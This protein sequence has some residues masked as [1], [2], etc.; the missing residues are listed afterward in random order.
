MGRFSPLTD[1]IVRLIVRQIFETTEW[2][3]HLITRCWKFIWLQDC[4]RLKLLLDS[5][6]CVLNI[7]RH[8]S[9]F[10]CCLLCDL[11]LCKLWTWNFLFDCLAVPFWVESFYRWRLF[12]LRL[13]FVLLFLIQIYTIWRPLIDYTRLFLVKTFHH[14][15]L[16]TLGFG[17]DLLF[18]FICRLWATLI[19][20][21][22]DRLHEAFRKCIALWVLIVMQNQFWL[23]SVCFLF[24]HSRSSLIFYRRK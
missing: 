18:H 24:L 3:V 10:L 19:A 1:L 22:K 23:L 12:L 4:I 16:M 21:L 7:H 5:W 2:I 20:F 15:L 6:H 17:C 13:I 8:A 9:L 14:F 11:F